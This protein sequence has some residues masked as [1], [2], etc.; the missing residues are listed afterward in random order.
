MFTLQQVECDH[1]TQ[2]KTLIKR[3]MY[4]H[5]MLMRNPKSNYEAG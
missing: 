4:I 3:K 2:A 5:K 1:K